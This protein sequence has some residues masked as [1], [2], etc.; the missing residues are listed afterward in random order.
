MKRR[1]SSAASDAECVIGERDSSGAS[2][3][4]ASPSGPGKSTVAVWARP[5]HY[6]LFEILQPVDSFNRIPTGPWRRSIRS[7]PISLVASVRFQLQGASPP[8]GEEY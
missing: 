5:P 7:A 6:G 8:S 3:S 4:G 2:P 1:R